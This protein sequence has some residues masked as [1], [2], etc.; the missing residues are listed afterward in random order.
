[1]LLNPG[2]VGFHR[3]NLLAEKMS[4]FKINKTP[5][6]VAEDSCSLYV[7]AH[8]WLFEQVKDDPDDPQ[9]HV[10]LSAPPAWPPGVGWGWG[11]VSMRST[12]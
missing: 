9:T 10:S 6:S 8:C 12:A 3:S 7:A 2:T 4:N 1:M 5:G 11:G